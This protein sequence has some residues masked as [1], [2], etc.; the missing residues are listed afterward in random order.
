MTARPQR[1]QLRIAGKPDHDEAG[2]AARTGAHARDARLRDPSLPA[3]AEADYQWGTSPDIPLEALYA[4]YAPY[5]AAIA[6]RI[7]G[8]ESEVEDLVQDVFATAVR[9]L[10]RRR[11]H[12]EVKRWL[13]T[14]TVR[15]SIRRLRL[16]ALWSWIDLDEEPHWDRIADPDVSPDERRL[17]AHVYRALERLP[18]RERV[19]WVLRHV[20][21]ESLQQVAELCGCSLATV[22]RRIARAHA[23]I[24]VAL[25]ARGRLGS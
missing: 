4:R 5:V 19:P 16:L 10:R 18:I 13:A 1:A 12:A 11:N 7:L 3:R 15:R 8:R 17:V 22:K 21:G 25:Q 24:S 14:V 9:G 2:S 6:M 23:R 20:E